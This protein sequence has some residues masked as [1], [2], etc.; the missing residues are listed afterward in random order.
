MEEYVVAFRLKSLVGQSYFL[1]ATH[2]IE[3]AALASSL[4][5]NEEEEH[6]VRIA[7]VLSLLLS[8]SASKLLL[9]PE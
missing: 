5:S 1:N 6:F 4:S 7:L 8:P 3:H 9:I 2:I